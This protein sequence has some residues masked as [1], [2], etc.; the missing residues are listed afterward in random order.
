MHPN[1]NAGGLAGPSDPA[2]LVFEQ[3]PSGEWAWLR[4][5]LDA[6]I[7]DAERLDRDM[8]RLLDQRADRQVDPEPRYT[9]TQAGRDYLARERAMGNLFGPWPTVADVEAQARDRGRTVA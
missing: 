7:R 6:A 5:E 1:A 2:G 8:P 9:L 4:P 3:L